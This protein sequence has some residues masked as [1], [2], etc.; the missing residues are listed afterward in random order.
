MLTHSGKFD[1]VFSLK[2]RTAKSE[3]PIAVP[4]VTSIVKFA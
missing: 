1:K 3:L 2:Q 4:L